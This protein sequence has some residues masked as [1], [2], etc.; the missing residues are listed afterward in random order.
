VLSGRTNLS[1]VVAEVGVGD[2]VSAG[3]GLEAGVGVG[4]GLGVA[5]P[6]CSPVWETDVGP[7]SEPPPQ[8]VRP[9]RMIPITEDLKTDFMNAHGKKCGRYARSQWLLHCTI[10]VNLKLRMYSQRTKFAFFPIN[11]SQ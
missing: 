6:A 8:A 7:P 11:L 2:D 10:A 5:E 4:V 1:S 9:Q 3:V